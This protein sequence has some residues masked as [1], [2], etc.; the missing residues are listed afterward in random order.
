MTAKEEFKRLQNQEI[1]PPKEDEELQA[2]VSDSLNELLE[3]E[4]LITEEVKQEFIEMEKNQQ[5]DE[6]MNKHNELLNMMLNIKKEILCN[7]K[8]HQVS[9]EKDYKSDIEILQDTH[10]I[11][12]RQG[13]YNFIVLTIVL[14]SGIGIGTQYQSWLPYIDSLITLAKT[15]NLFK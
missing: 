5:K 10:H 15:A 7:R 9:T 6:P 14:L 4:Q 2:I 3:N 8:A 13:K 12:L 1:K 11:K